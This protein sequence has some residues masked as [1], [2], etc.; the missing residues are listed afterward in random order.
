M[1]FA[2]VLLVILAFSSRVQACDDYLDP[3]DDG[4][5]VFNVK[6]EEVG[7]K[8]EVIFSASDDSHKVISRQKR[9][10]YGGGQ[11]ISIKPILVLQCTVT[12]Q[13]PI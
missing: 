4:D 9:G 11:V 13:V 2:A 6:N 8:Y 7:K 5:G 10:F 1:S 3:P 12:R